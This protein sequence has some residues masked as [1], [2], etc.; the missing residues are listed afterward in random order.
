MSHRFLDG[1]FGRGV[2]GKIFRQCC[3]KEAP[4]PNG[5]KTKARNGRNK[6]LGVWQNY[7]LA[8]GTVS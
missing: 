7:S 6:L 2:A 8:F 1:N 3:Q 4:P 5:I